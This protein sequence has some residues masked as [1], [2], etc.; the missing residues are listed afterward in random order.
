MHTPE[1]VARVHSGELTQ[2]VSLDFVPKRSA[3]TVARVLEHSDLHL[4]AGW[5]PSWPEVVPPASML[6]LMLPACG[7]GVRS[8]YAEQKL[9]ADFCLRAQ[10]SV[11]SFTVATCGGAMTLRLLA[12]VKMPDVALMASAPAAVAWPCPVAAQMGLYDDLACLQE[13][14]GIGFPWSPKLVQRSNCSCG[15]T[16][17]ATR[18]LLEWNLG[19]TCNLAGEVLGQC[20][21]LPTGS[22]L[23]GMLRWLP[24]GMIGLE[25]LCATLCFSQ[26]M[27]LVGGVL[28][29]VQ[30]GQSTNVLHG[31][32][33]V[34]CSANCLHSFCMPTT[35][36]VSSG[37]L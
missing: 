19:I 23:P 21:L 31:A 32:Y 3:N 30:L 16:L 18:A 6:Q 14:R 9:R 5:M 27:Q 29:A 17:A 26:Q 35:L 22:V 2:K 4:P 10:M 24:W 28:E 37:S 13:V 25:M 33:M 15:G 1:Y 20:V 11:I 36:R 8:Q 34:P 7:H 12:T